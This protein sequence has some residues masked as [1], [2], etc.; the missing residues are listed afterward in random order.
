ME[1]RCS[2]CKQPCSKPSMFLCTGV[3]GFLYEPSDVDRAAELIGQL[4]KDQDLRYGLGYVVR[5]HWE[6]RAHAACALTATYRRPPQGS[7]GT[8]TCS[9]D[10]ASRVH[11]NVRASARVCQTG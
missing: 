11:V 5:E 3:T 7:G 8:T 10:S 1:M 2:A 4:T 6:A 9:S